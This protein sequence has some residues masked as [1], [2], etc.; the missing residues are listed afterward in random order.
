MGYIDR[1]WA[2]IPVNQ[3]EEAAR[4]TE[5]G[6]GKTM[7]EWLDACHRLAERLPS[8]EM[9]VVWRNVME[10]AQTS[11]RQGCYLT[12]NGLEHYDR[13]KMRA[14]DAQFTSL[15]VGYTEMLRAL[16]IAHQGSLPADLS[17]EHWV[18][19]IDPQSAVTAVERAVSHVSLASLQAK[20]QRVEVC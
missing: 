4:Q 13:G 7:Q 15:F 9:D 14:A 20:K 3:L 2:S 6:A 16:T 5:I 12:Y 8:H 17:E 10:Q 19:Q 11:L 18:A 1:L